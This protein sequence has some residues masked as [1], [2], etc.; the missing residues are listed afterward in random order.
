[1]KNNNK[2][3]EYHIDKT[4]A[5]GWFIEVYRT[6]ERGEREEMH[7]S[8]FVNHYEGESI[9]EAVE[10]CRIELY[11]PIAVADGS[12]G[13]PVPKKV[14]ARQRAAFQWFKEAYA[15]VQDFKENI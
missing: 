7:L 4:D 2:G 3:Y 10:A 6:D 5:Q 12:L 15:S 13:H 9:E 14:L 8:M 1:M 11:D